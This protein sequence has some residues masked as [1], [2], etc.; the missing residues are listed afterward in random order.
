MEVFFTLVLASNKRYGYLKILKYR[1][2]KIK[3][4]EKK[5]E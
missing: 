1:F 4:E 3:F 5:E 2:Q